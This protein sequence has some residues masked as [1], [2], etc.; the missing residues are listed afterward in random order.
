M[1]GSTTV[2]SQHR[3]AAGS[4][5]DSAVWLNHRRRY[6][7]HSG[8]CAAADV[9]MQTTAD[10][11]APQVAHVG[12]HSEWS[13]IVNG[14]VRH[15]REWY[16]IVNAS[17]RHHSAWYT[18]PVRHHSE[19]STIVNASVR[20]QSAWYTVVN[21][22]VTVWSSGPLMPKTSRVGSRTRQRWCPS[23]APA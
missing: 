18:T 22:G 2:M 13:T 23:A 19:W 6:T 1:C 21:A 20:H 7:T 11:G 5:R 4:N 3:A 17:V 14:S 12:H 15:H 16:T 10:N 8:H 9:R